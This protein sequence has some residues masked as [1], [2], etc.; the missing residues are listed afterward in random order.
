MSDRAAETLSLV[1]PPTEPR[2][3]T[4]EVELLV[5]EAVA[6]G[7]TRPQQVT[8]VLAAVFARLGELKAEPSTL[9]A[10]GTGVRE[11]LL[12]QA[13]LRFWRG[14]DWFEAECMVC[15]TP[16]DTSAAL[17]DAPRAEAGSGYPV[18]EVSTSLGCRRFEA[19]NGR[20]EEALARMSGMPG[21]RDL[22]VLCGLAPTARDDTRR[23]TEGDVATIA[24]RFDE[25]CPDVAD[26]LSLTCP[27]CQAP[28]EARLDP[29]TFAFPSQQGVLRDVH[30]IA[31]AYHW[32][33]TEILALPASRRRAY[34]EMIQAEERG[35]A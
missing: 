5:A 24:N 2:P 18:I 13:A 19:P 34:V 32:R 21:Q 22:L 3:M 25:I 14:S 27:S 8:G 1:F 16:F 9:R 29:L 17:R 11:W 7:R 28:T 31:C 15:G 4:G 12:Q 10:L 6:K 35:R 23:F 30:R 33:E 20:H 26:Q